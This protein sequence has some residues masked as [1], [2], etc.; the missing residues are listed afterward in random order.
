MN[1]E[2]I[3]RELRERRQ[4]VLWR[5]EERDGKPTKVP[6]TARGRRASSTDPATWTSFEE[7]R[8]AA[9]FD[10]IGFVFSPDDPFTGIDLDECFVNGDLHPSALKIVQAL[11][12]YTERSV[13]GAGVHVLVRAELNGS[14]RRTGRTPWGAEFE[15]YNTGRYFCMT[16]DLLAGAAPTIE[17]RQAQLERVLGVVFPTPAKPS[18]VTEPSSLDDRDLLDRAFAATNG[19]KVERLYQGEADGYGSASEADL[20]LCS[21]LAFWTGPDPNRID[22]LFRSSGLMRDKWKRSDYRE[23]TISAA[24]GRSDFFSSAPASELRRASVAVDAET[25]FDRRE[26]VT[27]TLRPPVRG[28]SVVAV[29]P[30]EDETATQGP[31]A[32]DAVPFAVDLDDFIAARSEAPAALI[33]DESEV[34]LPRAGLLILFGKGG[35]GKTTAI[36]DFAFH[37]ASG[38]DWLGFEVAHPLRVLLVENEGPQE[39]FRAKLEWKRESWGHEIAGSLFIQTLNWGAFSLTDGKQAAR[40]RSFIEENEIDLVIG[41]PLDSLGLEGAGSPENTRRFMELMSDV[42]LFRSVAFALLHH[43]RKEGAQD[44]LD[45]AAGSWGGKPDTM[46]RLERRDGNRARLSFPKVRWSR[47]GTRP[48]YILSFDPE[49]ES[50]TVAHEEEDEERDYL[51]EIKA[52]LADGKART[53]KEIAAPKKDGGIGAKEETVESELESHRDVCVSHTGEEAKALGRS[54]LATVWVLARPEGGAGEESGS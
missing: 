28:S 34:I 30:V 50:F 45:E 14:R 23:R 18:V 26:D 24:L 19:A 53:K 20:A 10:G 8:A 15:T 21:C 43:P 3:P 13:S 29:A 27:A 4:W 32:V 2:A 40:L 36:I 31:V 46:L 54:P 17:D 42:G 33:G 52:L 22:R 11:D 5:Y 7:A 37:A 39:P 6:Y 1:P 48:A 41:H 44:E 49:T 12:S 51:A 35:R 16:G 25:E 9:G 47:R 38:V